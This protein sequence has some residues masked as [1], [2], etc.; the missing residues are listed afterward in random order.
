MPGKTS[1]LYARVFQQ[2][3]VVLQN[4]NVQ[5]FYLS[6]F[7]SDFELALINAIKLVFPNVQH[8]GCFFH[9]S[10]A[11]YRKLSEMGFRV[12]YKND[13]RFKEAVKCLISIGHVPVAQ[14]LAYFYSVMATYADDLDFVKFGNDYFHPTWFGR[15]DTRL[16]DWYMVHTRT[17]NHVEGYHAGLKHVFKMPHLAFYRFL[18]MLFEEAKT[19][20]VPRFRAAVMGLPRPKPTKL[21]AFY[22]ERNDRIMELHAQLPQRLPID[23]LVAIARCVP[24]PAVFPQ[25]A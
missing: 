2:I 14:K 5:L 6:S 10:Q 8:I 17:N 13:A 15:F 18:D 22:A 4:M 24:K 16:W 20:V 7:I 12:K 11:V 19:N 25:N 23:Y 9:F 1:E 21:Q 3:V